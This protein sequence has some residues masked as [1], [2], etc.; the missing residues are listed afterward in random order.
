MRGEV[1]TDGAQRRQGR[2]CEGS[3]ARSA[4]V[5]PLLRGCC[6]PLGSVGAAAI[7]AVLTACSKGP[8]GPEGALGP[9][10]PTGPTG[11]GA[12][13]PKG[14]PGPQ[15]LVGPAGSKGMR[16]MGAWDSEKTYAVDDVINSGGT[17]YIAIAASAGSPPPSASWS[18]VAS[19]GEVGAAGG[20]GAQGIKG[21]QGLQG[22]K[23]DKGDTGDKGD[24]GTQGIQGLPGLKGDKGDQGIQGNQG[25]KGDQGIQGVAG[26]QGP[27]GLDSLQ[28]RKYV[29]ML[30]MRTGAGCPSGWHLENYNDLVGGN[31]YVYAQIM[32]G[33]LVLGGITSPSYGTEYI[34]AGIAQT[35]GIT[36]FCWKAFDS[37]GRPHTSLLAGTSALTCPSGY[38][39]FPASELKGNN[40]YTYSMA[41]EAGFY[42]GYVDNGGTS[43]S[44]TYQHGYQYRYWTTEVATTCL[45]VMGVEDD[46][47]TKLGVLPVLIGVKD[48]ASCPVSNGYTYLQTSGTLAD[49]GDDWSAAVM[50]DNSSVFGAVGSRSYGGANW[51]EARFHGSHQINYCWKFYPLTGKP[52][53]M[54]RPLAFTTCPA[55]TLSF[56]VDKINGYNANVY[57]QKTGATVYLGGVYYNAFN[58]Y[59]DGYI[60]NNW[61]TTVNNFCLSADNVSAFP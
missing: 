50:N 23:G 4:A 41:T 57:Y 30:A 8:Q 2:R 44:Q 35:S 55:G 31:S 61:T 15:G 25:L 59:L 38:F 18:L 34:H 1:C 49:A 32:A 51:N 46:P 14:D 47:A 12:T 52:H 21:D 24:Q 27:Q 40:G 45:K 22:L 9:T 43:N 16:W 10:G 6:A 29:V 19:R 54:L 33:G 36:R 7:L 11:I 3:S 26:P 37:R 17:A 39:T 28:L 48:Q 56:P 53:V 5:A 42:L 58:D 13:G 60:Q 20:A